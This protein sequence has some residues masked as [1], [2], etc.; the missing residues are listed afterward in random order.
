MIRPSTA[1]AETDW[2]SA[3][4]FSRFGRALGRRLRNLR[5]TLPFSGLSVAP[6]AITCA[7]AILGTISV[8]SAQSLSVSPTSEAFGNV[9]VGSTS[10]TKAVS[11]TNT[12]ST[13]VSIASIV[14]SL[15]FGE[16]N[17]CGASLAPSA[18]CTISTTF[19]PTEAGAFTGTI[20]VTDGPSNS[21]QVIS[22]TG[23]GKAVAL[24]SIS[25]TPKLPTIGVG[26]QMQFTA[27][28]VFNNGTTQNLSS[29]V[30]WTA[31][32]NI[33]IGTLTPTGLCTGVAPGILTVKAISG[34][35]LGSTIVT[36]TATP[37]LVSIGVTPA[38][39][40]AAAGT[41]QQ[42]TATGNYSDGSTQ[43]LTTQVTWTSSSSAATISNTTGSNGL[44]TAV[45]QGSSN[46]T[47]TLGPV[48]GVTSLSVTPAAL[49]SI[50]ISPASAS[51]AQGV[52][53]QF[54]ATGTFT[55]GSTQNITA[56]TTWSSSAT[57]VATISNA[58]GRQGLATGLG[59][60]PTTIEATSGSVTKSVT[61]TVLAPALV[62][63]TVTPDSP[64]VALS[65][66]QQF[67]AT[68]TYTDGSSQNLTASAAW[69]SSA[70]GVASI[71][72][73]TGTQG[74]A[75]TVA[76]GSTTITATSASV[77]GN[78]VM[79]VASVTITTISVS[80]SS[81]SIPTSA[82]E[83]FTAT[84]TFSDG[85]TQNVT[86]SVQWSA[87]NGTVATVSNSA[88]TQG[89]AAPVASGVVQVTAT[90]GSV[91]GSG[92]L[93]IQGATL[94]SIAV[95]PATPSL[96]LGTTQQ[97]TATGTF[98]GGSTQNITSSVVWT[99]SNS[100]VASIT[101]G[102]L[103]S[104]AGTGTSLITATSGSISGST[105]ITYV[106]TLPTLVSIGVTPGNA[107]TPLGTTQQFTATGFYSNGPNQNLTSQVTWASSSPDVTI[108]NN[109]GSGGFD[110]VATTVAQGTATITAMLGTISGSTSL[111]VTPAALLSIAI[112]PSTLSTSPDLSQQFTAT[113]TY[114]N[115]STQDLTTTVLWS[116]SST[117]IMTI[118]NTSPTQGVAFSAGL[119]TATV[120]ATL[121][122]TSASAQ[123]TV[124]Q[125]LG[126]FLP[127]LNGNEMRMI[128][129]PFQGGQAL[130]DLLW[131]PAGDGFGPLYTEPGCSQCHST[132]V[133]G[134][135]GS[136]QDT[137]FGKLNSDGS[138]NTLANEGG[139]VL[140]IN[141]VGA[142]AVSS[143]QH[144]DNC[145][146]PVN[147]IPTD[148]TIVSLRQTPPVFGD[149]FIDA[150]P[151][152]TII[153]N[154]TFQA[155]DPV[156][157]ELGIHG[158][159]NMVVDLAG[160]LRTGRFGWKAQ[161]PTLLGFSGEAELIELGISDPELPNE[162]QPIVGTIPPSCEVARTEPNDPAGTSNLT[163]NF[164]AF[165]AF[166][167][168]PAP[169]APTAETIAGQ[170]TFVS[171]GCADCH[172]PSMQTQANFLVP[173]DYPAPLGSGT[174]DNAVVLSN[175][176]ANVFSD[177]LIHDMGPALNDSIP[178]GQASG[179]QWRTTPLWGLSHKV[180]LIHDGR[181]TGPNAIQCA[182]EAHGG[183]AAKVETSFVGLTP[184]QQAD[185]IAFLNSL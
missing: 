59:Q 55:D 81:A 78:T 30:T 159:P 40:S 10:N 123:F 39:P 80:P 9:F 34:L 151:D 53:Q 75:T 94:E 161:Q 131:K 46:V 139:P 137:R 79:T 163:V 48:S 153:A 5:A 92:A 146:L 108:T 157:Q 147:T 181:C 125:P 61:L 178:Q 150:I 105:T 86:Q 45:A 42:F 112:T 25:V 41:T 142:Q 28:G 20:T 171:I 16:T 26:Q 50:A 95:T 180:F 18:K 7:I 91:S 107:S 97:F 3:R 102:G 162:N 57:S 93:T 106:G 127:G 1:T 14:P 172:I 133:P 32:Q 13:S 54:T 168:P 56:T 135:S 115:G 113:G 109:Q 85:S 43:N 71:S 35:V 126:S 130:F 72:N 19:T 169:A 143:F 132:P 170:A 160:N 67:T 68:G 129:L 63:I 37:T 138:F 122:V 183:E 17:T 119:G 62:G 23:T 118:S 33:A 44:A 38:N 158:V 31:I 141:S 177:L 58:A 82:T 164:A 29:S 90:L 47:A 155:N 70:V 182:I 36:V 175:Q 98:S 121:G 6:A 49:V 24:S 144:L 173:R 66:S 184:T 15:D 101:A 65:T 2:E 124:T 103:A 21:Q 89:L 4:L 64:A 166:L 99:S 134:G 136:F 120:A 174:V 83:Q 167:A 117:S 149:G 76:A 185:L 12:G 140:H 145:I 154:E 156:S 69:S 60:G 152:S 73:A 148:A 116:S 77:S 84:G 22:L 110:G 176:T 27:T 128:F 8:A 74:L 52:T 165:S 96:A 179:S 88:P 87:G 11:L 114:T 111:T 51:I 100:S 104:S